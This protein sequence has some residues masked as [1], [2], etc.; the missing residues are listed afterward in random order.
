M[1]KP[2]TSPAAI[3]DAL[4]WQGPMAWVG[5]RPVSNYS[6]EFP[7]DAT[8]VR[9]ELIFQLES[10]TGPGSVRNEERAVPGLLRLDRGKAVEAHATGPD[11]RCWTY[12]RVKNKWSLL[13][14]ETFP[15]VDPATASPL[16]PT[17]IE[18]VVVQTVLPMRGTGKAISFVISGG[19]AVD[20]TREV[21]PDECD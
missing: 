5:S 20:L 18:R 6:R 12:R 2:N 8:F 9:A 11:G 4:L 3:P 17:V 10:P 7:S 15:A 19:R 21:D 13:V 16:G 14:G 1:P